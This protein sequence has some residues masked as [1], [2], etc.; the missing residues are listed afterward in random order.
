MLPDATPPGSDVADDAADR[1]GPLFTAPSF[2][3]FCGLACGFVAQIGKRTVCGMLAGAGL[4]RSWS[5]DRAHSFFSRARWNSDGLGLAVARLAV[6]LL[7]PAVIVQLPCCSRPVA[8]PV[9]AAWKD[10]A[11]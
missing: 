6:A 10:L 9:L 1:F 2:R 8:L 3:T 7:V 5:H 11:A 4:S